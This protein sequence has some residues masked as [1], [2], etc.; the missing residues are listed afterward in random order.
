MRLKDL[1]T[2]PAGQK[3][4]EKHLRRVL[5]S[6]ICSILLCMSCLVSTTWS[7]FAVSIENTGNVIQIGTPE[8]TVIV[9][10]ESVTTGKNLSAGKYDVTI[11]RPVNQDD[12][13]KKM[14]CVVILTIQR[15][16]EPLGIYK[17]VV[18]E[19]S[20]VTIEANCDCVLSWEASWF[21]P[22]SANEISNGVITVFAEN[23]T[24]PSTEPTTAP[25]SEAEIEPSTEATTTPSTEPSTEGTPPTTVPSTEASTEPST[26][27]TTESSTEQTTDP[28][29]ATP[30]ETN[31]TESGQ[32]ET[33][34]T[35]TPPA[36]TTGSTE[37]TTESTGE[38][39]DVV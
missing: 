36:E 31:P 22:A 23:T 6:S 13:Q 11:Q 1:F 16:N 27:A 18:S 37:S 8:V 21:A 20:S 12:L 19:S 17:I 2:V 30:P 28:T 9:G 33:T 24:D 7:W 3:V 29:T 14:E 10:N 38:S 4:T 32:T 25:S 15:N 39:D 34:S 35:T 26:E 5:I